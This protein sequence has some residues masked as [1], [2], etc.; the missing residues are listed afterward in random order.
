MNLAVPL[1]IARRE[2]RTGTRGFRTFL[3]CLA[4]GIGA[5]SAVGSIRVSIEDGLVRQGAAILGGDAELTFSYRFAS[6]DERG[7]MTSHAR[8]VS[9]TVDFRTMASRADGDGEPVRALTQLKGVDSLYPLYGAVALDPGMEFADALS[10]K[11][12]SP[13]AVM[14]RELAETLGLAIGDFFTLGTATFRLSAILVREPDST[15]GSFFLAPRTIVRT[16][17]LSESGLLGHGTRFNSQ[18][19]LGLAPG[20]DLQELRGQARERFRDAGMLWRDRL[21]P[22]PRTRA[23][24]QRVAAFLV[25]AGLAGLAVGGVGVASAVS[26]FL[27]AKTTTIAT[28]RSLGASGRT[29]L[30]VYAIQTSVMTLAAVVTGVLAGTLAVA[31]LQPILAERLPLPLPALRLNLGPMAEAA[32]YGVLVAAVFSLWPLSRTQRIRAAELFR[33]S[34]TG[35]RG[36]PPLPAALLIA[37]LAATL[38]VAAARFSGIAFITYWA[39]AGIVAAIAALALAAAAIRRLSRRL[40]RARV[41]Q[42]RTALRLALG[43]V[44]GPA[45]ETRAV[46]ISLGLSLS[47]LAA[48]G[49]IASNLNA[50]IAENLPGIAPAFFLVDIQNSQFAEFTKTAESHPGVTRVET[51]P[52]LRGVIT[53]INGEDAVD[54]A[55]EHWTLRGDRGLTYS[56][57]MPD[58]TVLTAG[59]WWPED[60][61]GPP[62]VSFAAEEAEELGIGIGD[63]ITVNVLGRN[64]DLRISSLRE[65]DFS[66]LGIGFIM[67]LNPS[68]LAGAPH[69]HIATVYGDGSTSAE[70]SFFR[71][72]SV[73]FPNVTVIRVRDGIARAREILAG[74]VAAVTY[75]ASATLVTGFVVLVGAAAAGE[76]T[77]TFEAAVLRT[78][79]AARAVILAS[80]ALRSALMGAAA[81]VVAIVAGSI[82]GWA[83]MR[84]VMQSDYSFEPASAFAIVTG[85]ALV[86]LLAGTAFAARALRASPAGVLRERE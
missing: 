49:Q 5:I 35:L 81:G 52:M 17:A 48:V 16:A 25:L 55:G 32:L 71:A 21:D 47:V 37:A 83:V 73:A 42:G 51:A 33:K 11:D 60:Y 67:S 28:L 64:M 77:R 19:R 9:E 63:Q 40:S 62:L 78:L 45:S 66:T 80:F 23:L 56:G 29:V 65:V 27:N 31:A 46:V 39:A 7:W 58:G 84:F 15:G 22:G 72:V 34:A 38:V 6:D 85:G 70:D 20:A 12:G 74:F 3:A 2:L 54:A 4:I 14:Q 57:R 79:G 50:I 18:Y 53:R 61:A 30:A 68:A 43:S 76:A 82:A 10:V 75:G 69:T 36:S 41:A 86:S 13:G 1:K 59:E 8:V 24:V 44:G 26:S